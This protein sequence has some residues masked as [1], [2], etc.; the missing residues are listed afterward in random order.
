MNI[1]SFSNFL[2][3]LKKSYKAIILGFIGGYIGTIIHLPLPWLLGSILIN[4]IV[5][6]TKFEIQFSSKLLNPI[7]LIIGIILGGALNVTLLYN[8]H[9][10]VF[11]SI[12][13][14]LCVIVSTIVVTFYFIK[15]LKYPKLIS[16]LSSLPGGFAT[17]SAAVLELKDN[18][19]HQKVLLS[20]ATRV[21]FIVSLLP[22]IF[23]YEKGAA[24]L[25]GFNFQNIYNVRYFYEILFIIGLSFIFSKVLKKFKIPSAMLLSGMFISGLFYTFEIIDAR[26]PDL[27]INISFVFLGTALGSRLN[28]LR[29]KDLIN[30]ILN[31]IVVTALLVLISIIFAYILSIT[32]GF[33][34]LTAFL[35]FAPGGI[36]EMVVIAIAYNTD[37]IFVS[38][39]HFLRIF[40]IV[41]AL[42]FIIKKFNN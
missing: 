10:W 16:I 1:Q 5:S 2:R 6:F 32:N 9:L 22:I 24:N 11:S 37:P 21:I 40:V 4:L 31:G 26:F 28:G 8:I 25:E 42:P 7:F 33:D 3:S 35:S 20:Q 29:L 14:I 41:F 36:H 27:F 23:F 12:M 30:I 19:I 13:M 39:H 38:Y 18:H 17:I 15:V 34:F